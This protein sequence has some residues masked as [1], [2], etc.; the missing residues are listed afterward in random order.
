MYKYIIIGLK[1]QIQVIKKIPVAL[2]YIYFALFNRITLKG[3][4]ATVWEKYIMVLA[5][6]ELREHPF[7][8][9]L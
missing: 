6:E 1:I 8:V 3:L 2:G 7:M 5:L 9:S 4:S